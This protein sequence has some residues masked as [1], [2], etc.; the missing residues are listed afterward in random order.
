MRVLSMRSC[1]APKLRAHA[2]M[3][4]MRGSLM[5]H[6]LF[7]RMTAAFDWATGLTI[8]TVRLCEHNQEEYRMTGVCLSGRE[9]V[10]VD[11]CAGM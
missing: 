4:K 6:R 9:I 5:D 3:H 11:G 10:C 1:R 8:L 7:A 2:R